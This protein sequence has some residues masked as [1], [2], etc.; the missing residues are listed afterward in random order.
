MPSLSDLL[1]ALLDHAVEFVVIGGFAA[2]AHGSSILTQDLDLCVPFTAMNCERLLKALSA[3]H[4]RHRENKA[5]LTSSVPALMRFK[6]IYLVTD[7]GPLDLLGQVTG[8][9]PYAAL[10]Q[11]VITLP[12]HDRTCRIL[13]IEALITAKKSMG[14]PKDKEVI[15]QL[16]AIQNAPK[17]RRK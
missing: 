5:P 10:E 17:P 3:F 6:N 1:V 7:A 8:L 15:V 12:L 9:G 2:V 16:Q 13:D 4:P 14:R 11:H